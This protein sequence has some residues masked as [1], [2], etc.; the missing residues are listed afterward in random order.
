MTAELTVLALSG[1]LLMV[2]LM[3]MGT[4]ANLEIGS[5]YFLSPRDEKPP[6]SGS[7]GLGRLR[8]AYINHTEALPLFA[9]AVIVVT[10]AEKS[11]GFTAACAW[12]YLGARVLFIPAYLFGW[13]PW[14]SV[15]WAVGFF[16]TL[17]MF[18]AALI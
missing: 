15:I 13:N 6:S 11:S 12:A 1:I 9:A 18:V 3:W 10:L 5:T 8:R 16:A 14:R 4:R 17:A 2:H 7:V